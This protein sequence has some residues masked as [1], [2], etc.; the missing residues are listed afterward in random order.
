M[1]AY[2]KEL[3]VCMNAYVREAHQH[4]AVLQENQT[5]PRYMFRRCETASL[6]MYVPYAR[7]QKHTHTYTNTYIF[8]YTQNTPL[9]TL[10]LSLVLSLPPSLSP[11]LS[12]S[13]PPSLSLSLPPSHVQTFSRS[14]TYPVRPL[15]S[16]FCVWQSS[17]NSDCVPH[18][19][20]TRPIRHFLSLS[21]PPAISYTV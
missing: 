21:P 12:L 2:V 16:F 6:K 10:S 7:I 4:S 3:Y 13:L 14:Y 17:S 11:P 18:T 20:T 19:H 5:R 9:P 1:H 15:F 8:V